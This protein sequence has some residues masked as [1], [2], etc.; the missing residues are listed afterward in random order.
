[1][2][3]PHP[4]PGILDIPHYVPGKARIEGVAHPLKLSA[5]ENPLG[6]SPKAREAYLAAASSLH[7]YPDPRAGQLR[8]AVAQAFDLEPERLIFGCGSDELFNFVCQAFCEP[9]DNV[10]QPAHGFAAWAIAARAAGAEVRNAPERDLTVDVD[11]LL[12]LVDARTRIVFL[13]N[14]ANPTGTWLP[15]SQVRRLHA[16]LPSET[17]LLLDAAY[18]EF[19]RDA[20]GYEDGLALARQAQNVFLTRTFSKLYGLAT[21]RAGWGY[22][23]EPMI[24]AM[25]RIRPPFNLSRPAEAAAAAGLADTEFAER[26]LDLVARWRPVYA[27][28]LAAL[29]LEPAPSA[30]N[31]ITF[32]VPPETGLTAQGLEQALAG[33]GVLV[34]GLANYGLADCLRITFGTDEQSERVLGLIA[35]IAGA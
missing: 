11:A 4:K 33:H 13:A 28:R 34:R 3:A 1:M 30:T 2:S 26:S 15:F 5:N 21:L 25:D 18:C 35:A 12:A 20:E 14:P 17:I 31:F 6:C 9:G 24:A 32:R 23:P 29:G 19:A 8:A 16:A 7:L 10:V 27:A 22:A